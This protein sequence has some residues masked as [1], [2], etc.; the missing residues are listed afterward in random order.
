MHEK[1]MRI[2]DL[3]QVWYTVLPTWTLY[4][5]DFGY[6]DIDGLKNCQSLAEMFFQ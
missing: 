2:G 1:T 6:S 3:Q 4:T 5:E